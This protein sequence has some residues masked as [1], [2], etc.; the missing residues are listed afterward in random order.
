[1]IVTLVIMS[2]G[3]A[4]CETRASDIVLAEVDGRPITLEDY[5]TS[6]RVKYRATGE[7]AG[8]T[9]RVEHLNRMVNRSAAV[10]EARAQGITFDMDEDKLRQYRRKMLVQELFL[11]YG[12]PD[13]ILI[14]E[15]MIRR[16]Y[17][18]WR[19]CPRSGKPWL[20]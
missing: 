13:T 20:R 6:Y 5:N 11:I 2:G 7:D 3:D 19:M 1:M 16:E 14:S 12:R 9:W 8:R 4:L 10:L 18:K 15:E 17:E